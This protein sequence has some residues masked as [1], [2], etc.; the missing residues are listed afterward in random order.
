MIGKANVDSDILEI[1]KFSL[2]AQRFVEA[3]IFPADSLEQCRLAGATSSMDVGRLLRRQLFRLLGE[4]DQRT[5]VDVM[6]P[7]RRTERSE[8][9]TSELQSLMRTSY[10]VF[11]L[12]KKHIT[13]SNHSATLIVKR[14]Q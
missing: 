3:K 11:C 12:K 1:G 14:S 10:A 8:E 7:S 4:P 5:S 9:H 2:H 13:T 6:L